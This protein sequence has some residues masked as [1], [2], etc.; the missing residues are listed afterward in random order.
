[1]PTYSDYGDWVGGVSGSIV[2]VAAMFFVYMTYLIQRKQIVLQQ[3]EISKKE[4]D[5]KLAS[6]EDRYFSTISLHNE[7]VRN[8]DLRSKDDKGYCRW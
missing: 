2:S 6:L 8:L 5:Q 4:N 7:I 1:V 3:H